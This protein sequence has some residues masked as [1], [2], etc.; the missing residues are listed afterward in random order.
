M[1]RWTFEHIGKGHSAAFIERQKARGALGGK[2]KSESY[3][4]KRSAA[5]QLRSTGLTYNEIAERLN[6][7]L[8]TIKRWVK[9]D[10]VK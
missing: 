10:G 8:M 5:V 9:A 1:A 2:A 6:V 4:D 3:A 7:S